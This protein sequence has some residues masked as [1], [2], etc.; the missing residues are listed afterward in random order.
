MDQVTPLV[1]MNE[2][3][4]LETAPNGVTW[5]ACPPLGTPHGFSTRRG[6]ESEGPFAALNLGVSAGDD[7]ATVRRNRAAWAT[8]LGMTGPIQ[9][10]HQIHG[11]DVQA[12]AQRAQE[13]LY[14]DAI[15]SATPGLP[16]GIYTADCTPILLHD[17][18]TGAVGAVHAGWRGTVARV[19]M[20]AAQRMVD[21]LGGDPARL[22]AAIGPAIG[23]CCF[24]VGEEVAAAI[25]AQGWP[26]WERAIVRDARPKPHVDLFAAN[27]DQLLA[28]GLRAENVFVS[29]AC[30][31]CD[32]D[33]YFS[34]RRDQG[35]TGRMQA[36][37]MAVAR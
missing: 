31:S 23:P 28:F 10:M 18:G 30:T 11:G 1:M 7:E 36:A 25:A 15:V 13:T 9:G 12:V 3:F 32:A 27:R 17:P 2:P 22:R 6:G 4:R 29:H 5:L 16:I 35:R 21:E 24:E 20:N 26:G 33:H 14:G 8:A 19:V 34:W 37:I